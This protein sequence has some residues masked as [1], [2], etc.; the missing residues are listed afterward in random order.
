MDFSNSGNPTADDNYGF[1]QVCVRVIEKSQLRTQSY[2]GSNDLS[3]MFC[4]TEQDVC[5]CVGG[6]GGGGNARVTIFCE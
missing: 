2:N 4:K 5:V 6:G 1:C 3:L